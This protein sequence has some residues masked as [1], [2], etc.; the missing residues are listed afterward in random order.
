M[1]KRFTIVNVLL[2]FYLVI[3]VLHFTIAQVFLPSLTNI[4]YASIFLCLVL[5]LRKNR[6][7]T[8][9]LPLVLAA[10]LSLI[11]S[12]NTS[13]DTY[14]RFVSWLVIL[15]VAAPVFQNKEINL[16]RDRL[17]DW[18]I[19]IFI[20]IV[21]GSLI[22]VSLKLPSFNVGRLPEFYGKYYLRNGISLH[23]MVLAPMAGITSL[24]AWYHLFFLRPEKKK[25]LLLIALFFISCIVMLMASSRTVLVAIVLTW[26]FSFVIS[27]NVFS[28]AI[29]K[30]IGVVSIVVILLILS[31]AP[32]L[33]YFSDFLENSTRIVYK[34]T[35][36]SREGLWKA[37]LAD[38]QINPLSGAG[39]ATVSKK[40]MARNNVQSGVS[41]SGQVEF[42]ALYGHALSTMGLIGL[43][44]LLILFV[45]LL[46]IG[47]KH[48]K[49]PGAH[50]YLTIF[51]FLAL[52][53]LA[54]T[55]ILTSGAI[56]CVFSWL[57]YTKIHNLQYVH[58]VVDEASP[59]LKSLQNDPFVFNR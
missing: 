44:T 59:P 55:H 3:F 32:A 58:L 8:I 34:G 35:N 18:L 57:L 30:N 6:L 9:V 39:F 27:F 15:A 14:L 40:V 45:R 33:A 56:L 13:V 10:I 28:R 37:R 49:K 25:K 46:M 43:M 19:Y 7:N 11:F 23:E 42:G 1:K 4:Y 31:I 24:Y 17:W 50:L 22:W 38:F 53:N 51:V 2:G 12:T 26:L 41:D 54:E 36:N 5:L 52:Q 47:L 16:F 48:R 29:K 20:F 21:I